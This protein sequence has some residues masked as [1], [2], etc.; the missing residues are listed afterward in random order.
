MRHQSSA[1]S[2]WAPLGAWGRPFTYSNVFSSGAISPARAPPSMAMLQTVM[3]PSIESARIASPQYSMTCPVPPAVPVAPMT[4][5]VMSFAVTPGRRLP[6]IST[7]HVPGLSLDQR[8]GR[9]HVLDLARADPVGQRAERA[10]RGRM[11]VAA[12]DR[13]ARQGPALLGPDDV[14]DALAD[15]A[16]GVVVDAELGGVRVERGDLDGAVLGHVGRVLAAGRGRHVVVGHRDGPLGR[17][18]APARH[19]QALE[20][21][22][23]RDLVHQVPVDVEQRGAVLGLL[24][25]VGVP[26]L[27]VERL[28]GH[29][30]CPLGRGR[31]DRRR[32]G[33]SLSG[34]RTPRARAR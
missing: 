3:R 25:E 12:D 19:A 11:A 13:H 31:S 17:A 32:A 26:D 30:G 33:A 9:Q 23:A 5:S 28:A 22:G 29:G 14:H 15:V 34:A 6:V 27:V 1:A 2:H 8:L 20:G 4:E 18:H 16:H 10:V 24:D 21:L 7:L